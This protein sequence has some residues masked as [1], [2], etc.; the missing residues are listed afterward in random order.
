MH[1]LITG[2]CGFVG[3]NLIK[4]LNKKFK[5]VVIDNESLGKI[6]NLEGQNVKF[7]KIDICDHKSVE[8]V[9]LNH[10]IDYVIHLAAHTRVLESIKDPVKTFNNNVVGTFNLLS[11]SSK[12]KVKKFINA[13]TGGAI[14]GEKKPPISE[15]MHPSPLSI[16][17]GSKFASEMFCEIFF[18]SY[19]MKFINLRFSNLYGPNSFHK[20]SV[21]SLFIKQ[22]LKEKKIIVYGN[23]K[24]CRDF[25][26]IEYLVKFFEKCIFSNITGTYQLGSGKPTSLN[27]LIKIL[28]KVF[29]KKKNKK[30]GDFKV[31]YKAFRSG[32]IVKTW[33]NIEKAK[34]DLDFN[35][36]TN[37]ETGVSKTVNYF[38]K[39]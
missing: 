1:I 12:F 27:N 22:I 35:P 13:S 8:K 18:R 26:F 29:V 28:K 5:I 16:Y 19:D 25:L 3:V 4:K 30:Y 21:V 15:K 31:V 37:L 33:C 2:G 34:K 38:L 14:M 32:E 6:S 36:S 11:I 24:Q 23:G 9:F 20:D 17:G 10:K 7:Y 39:K